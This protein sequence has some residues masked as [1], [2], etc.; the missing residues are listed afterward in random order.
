MKKIKAILMAA[1]A[2]LCLPLAACSGEESNKGKINQGN[3]NVFPLSSSEGG[4]TLYMGDVMPFYDDGVMNIYH[5][6]DKVGSKY[7]FYHPF[8]RLTTTDYVTYKDEGIA[9]N[10]V[11]DLS[12]PD[13]ALGTG[14]FIKG[15]DGTY[16]C[17][18]TGHSDPQNTGLPYMEMIRH[19]TSKDGQKT[20]QKEEDFMIFGDSD[21]FRDPY[22]YYDSADSCYYML[23][24]TRQDGKGV[25]MQYKAESLDAA[26]SDW[27]KQGVFFANDAGTYN[28]EC[29]S[30]IEYNGFW[31]LAYSEQTSGADRVTHYRYQT[32]KG[33]EWKKFDLDKIDST[34]FY[35][36]R[37]EKAGDKLY[38]FAWCAK[39]TAGDVGEFDWGGNLVVH[40]IKQSNSGE[41]HA[42]MVENVKNA[43]KSSVTYN[44]TNGE[45][46][47]SFSFKGDKFT[48]YGLE[49]LSTN[50]TRM[51]FTVKLD[52]LKGDFGVTFGIDGGA[53]DNRLGSKVLAFKP[54]ENR[55]V[56]YNDVVNILRYGGELTAV[57]YK[58]ETGKEYSVDIVIDGEIVVLYFNS[59]VALSTRLVGIQK[60]G[61][62][63]YSNGTKASVKGISFYE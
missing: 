31:Y 5:L 32:E 62:A 51:H 24:T 9:L 30:Y 34:G 17:F 53:Y 48:A 11:E 36:G 14:S 7:M 58:F 41:L 38:A 50:I 43:F 55:I 23:V 6:Q 20:W 42:V 8:G 19:A 26:A 54:E 2:L 1:T 63:F 3:K 22:V 35:A 40:E 10:Y 28:M 46:A 18:Y 49:A 39:L 33:G 12:S 56:C 57:P 52:D 15:T 27:K 21:D 45:K 25:I 60:K 44:R 16:H 37:L 59:E 47:S 61:L 4:A 13:T 29:P